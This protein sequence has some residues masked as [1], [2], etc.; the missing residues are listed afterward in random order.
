[1]IHMS[2]IQYN[3]IENLLKKTNHIRGIAKELQTNQTT[4]AR[5]VQELQQENILD[6]HTQG[7]NKVFFLKKNLEA[8]Q[9]IYLFEHHKLL[10]IIKKYPRLRQIIQTIRKN[11][12]IELAVLFGSYAKMTAGK[13]S[14]IDIYICSTNPQLKKELEQIDSLVSIKIGKYDPANL[15]IKEIEKKHIILKGVEKYYEKNKLLM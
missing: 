5:K 4:I 13:E 2:Q 11:N 1:M 3:I 15:L 8:Q 12:N 6:F 7:R 9:Y 14:D 10:E